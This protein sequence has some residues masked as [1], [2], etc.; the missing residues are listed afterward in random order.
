M[1]D[2]LT[3]IWDGSTK[4]VPGRTSKRTLLPHGVG[5]RGAPTLGKSHTA[6]H[7]VWNEAVGMDIS[8]YPAWRLLAEQVEQVRLLPRG[9]SCEGP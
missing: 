7:R 6:D 2:D 8:I 4:K 5:Y 1:W 3:S 9:L